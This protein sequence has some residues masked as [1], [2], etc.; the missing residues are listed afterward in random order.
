MTQNATP[1][2]SRRLHAFVYLFLIAL[3]SPAA[4]VLDGSADPRWLSGLALAV[5]TACFIFQVS[6]QHHDAESWTGGDSGSRLRWQRRVSL[7]LVMGVIATATTLAWGSQWLVLFMF[8][9]V[10]AALL[11]PG[12]M[13]PLVIGSIAAVAVVVEVASG[14]D[15]VSATTAGSWALSIVMAGFVAAL[16]RRRNLLIAELRATQEE[17]A[18][19]AAVDAVADERLRFARDLHDLLGHSLSLIVLKAELARRLLERGDADEQARTEVTELEDAARRALVEVREAVAGYRARSLRTELERSSSAL[20][21][22]GVEVTVDGVPDSRAVATDATPPPI[23]PPPVDELLAWVVREATTNI[24][25]HSSARHAHV[26]VATGEHEASLEVTDDGT[27]ADE[28]DW[29]AAARSGGSGLL[30]L[31]ERVTA[32]GGRFTA[33]PAAGG[34]FRVGAVVPLN[35]ATSDAAARTGEAIRGGAAVP[36]GTASA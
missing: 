30:G 7:V 14:W 22:A 15:V 31:Q 36:D 4:E 12:R 16:M 19:L 29:L 35:G 34:G 24:V 6:V 20:A 25:R 11:V 3:A 23:F 9:V 18:R 1:E 28:W 17:V 26:A 5:F 21:A 13:A 2:S 27:G 10:V 8:V 33:G 32:A